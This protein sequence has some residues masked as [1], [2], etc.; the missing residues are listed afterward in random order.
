MCTKVSV[1][2]NVILVRL[3]ASVFYPG[4]IIYS[5]SEYP[6]LSGQMTLREAVLKCEID[7]E[8]AGFTFM[9]TMELELVR[10]IGFFRQV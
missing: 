9:G 5:D 3:C 1:L 4:K 2:L 10:R 8:C 7:L 6:Q